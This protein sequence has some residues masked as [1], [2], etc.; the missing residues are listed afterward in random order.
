MLPCI[1]TNFVLKNTSSF[2]ANIYSCMAVNVVFVVPTILLNAS[3]IIAIFASQERRE[4]C[5]IL[6]I[7]LAITDLGAGLIS[8]P[9]LIAEFWFVANGKDPCFF[10][11]VT[12]PIG[13]IFGLVSIFC[14]AALAI[15]RYMYVFKP[16]FHSLRLTTSA[17][18]FVVVGTWLLSTLLMSAYLFSKIAQIWHGVSVAI[19]ISSSVVIIY[20]YSKI[21]LR[22]R[23]IRRQIRT[24]AARLGQP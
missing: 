11:K 8:M 7:N 12:L 15:E 21:L 17:S 20:C 10:A 6:V 23:T 13:Y 4:P 19:A 18:I 9:N 5:Q 3:L 22:S 1:D 24:E 2:G 16:Y 14:I